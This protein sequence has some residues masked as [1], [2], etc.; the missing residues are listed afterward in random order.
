MWAGKNKLEAPNTRGVCIYL[1][2]AGHSWGRLGQRRKPK[3]PP[4]QHTGKNLAHFLGVFFFLIQSKNLRL[5][6]EGQKTLQ[7]PRASPRSTASP[8]ERGGKAASPLGG[9]VQLHKWQKTPLV[10]CTGEA[11]VVHCCWRGRTP[12]P[13]QPGLRCPVLC[14]KQKPSVPG[15]TSEW[16]RTSEKTYSGRGPALIQSRGQPPLGQ[17]Q[18]SCQWK[19]PHR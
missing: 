17:G 4:Q 1:Q 7:F 14:E 3:S 13:L 18:E 10:P 11:T 12:S 2:A 5:L 8:R 16:W 15:G 19:T 6:G 9:A